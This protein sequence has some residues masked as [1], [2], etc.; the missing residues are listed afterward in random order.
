MIQHDLVKA[1][2]G[3]F[4]HQSNKI[5]LNL[6][7]GGVSPVHLIS[8]LPAV[9]AGGLEGIGH[10]ASN[11]LVP[12]A[13]HP[14]HRVHIALIPAFQLLIDLIILSLGLYGRSQT[15][16]ALP[17]QLSLVV[18]HVHHDAVSALLLNLLGGASIQNGG[19]R[20][21]HPVGR[22]FLLRLLFLGL[23]GISL[24]RRVAA[25]ILVDHIKIAHIGLLGLTLEKGQVH[26]QPI[27]GIGDIFLSPQQERHCQ[28]NQDCQHK[29]DPFQPKAGRFTPAIGMIIK[30]RPPHGTASFH[31]LLSGPSP[32]L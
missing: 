28:H 8:I 5:I 17:P 30:L 9:S 6:L 29:G 22:S 2:L 20:N 19:Q 18:F 1:H 12:E 24:V 15:L 10:L 32:M 23:R 26:P 13:G 11:R 31:I 14:C 7:V 21:I 3:Q 16:L 4:R 27:I 25:G